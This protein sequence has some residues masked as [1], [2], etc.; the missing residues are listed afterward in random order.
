MAWAELKYANICRPHG[1]WRGGAEWGWKS[2]RHALN[3]KIHFRNNSFLFKTK[4]LFF[5]VFAC[6][7]VA[8]FLV[9]IM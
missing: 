5:V 6:M 1:G 9:F 3:N 7:Y 4:L 2:E 8:D